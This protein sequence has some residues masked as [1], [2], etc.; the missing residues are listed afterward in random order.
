M[1]LIWN[2]PCGIKCPSPLALM[3]FLHVISSIPLCF[4]T[5]VCSMLDAFRQSDSI[6][7]KTILLKSALPDALD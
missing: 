1:P 6:M 2:L 5:S 7:E 4:E 3:H